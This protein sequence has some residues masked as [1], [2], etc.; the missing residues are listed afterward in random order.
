MGLLLTSNRSAA[1]DGVQFGAHQD[2]TKPR[3]ARGNAGAVHYGS[4]LRTRELPAA[5]ER[6]REQR[7]RLRKD[8]VVKPELTIVEPTQSIDPWCCE[9][10]QPPNI[11][12]KDKVPRRPKQVRS[13]NCSV[14]ESLSHC[15][16]GRTVGALSHR[17][18]R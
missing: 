13:E 15:T 1:D 6:F 14:S 9:I 4:E 12:W 10:E 2:V 16:V 5:F 11:G 17:P 18:F 7:I 3:A 8:R